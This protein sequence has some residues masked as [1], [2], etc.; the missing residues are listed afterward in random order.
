MK[1]FALLLVLS[2]AAF[3]QCPVEIHVAYSFTC[4]VTAP[5]AHCNLRI[6]YKN[7]SN[8]EIAATKFGLNYYDSTGDFVRGPEYYSVKN[9][10]KAGKKTDAYWFNP[11]HAGQGHEA[12]VQK[13]LFTD[14]STW[15]D[16][17]SRSCKL[18]DKIAGDKNF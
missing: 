14:G 5:N 2:T 11:E 10:V 1:P 17:G 7:T 3:A 13:V 9:K 18:R 15:E 8:K 16:D 6:A 4:A 12:W